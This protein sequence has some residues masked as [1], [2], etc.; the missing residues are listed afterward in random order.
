MT[1]RRVIYH[2]D[3]HGNVA[4]T[5]DGNTVYV[6]HAGSLP[7][8]AILAE[9]KAGVVKPE[10]VKEADPLPNLTLRIEILDDGQWRVTPVRVAGGTQEAGAARTIAAPWAAEPHFLRQL[11]IFEKLSSKAVA[12]DGDRQLL[13][14]AARVVGEAL[15]A[16][17]LEAER[18]FLDAEARRDGPSPL[19]LLEATDDR[20][21]TLPWELV[22]HELRFPVFDGAWDVAR[23]IPAEGAP[24]LTPPEEPLRLLLNVAAP[25]GAG[26]HYEEESYRI[27]KALHHHA[28]V[29]VNEMGE[30]EDLAAAVKAADAA[31]APLVGVH[32][33]GHGG[34]GVLLFEDAFGEKAAVPVEALWRA[35]Q[36]EDLH[37]KLRFLYLGCCHGNTP[38][39]SGQEGE[40]DGEG[41]TATAAQLHRQG[42]T[43]VVAFHGPVYDRQ[44]TAAE[45]AFYRALGAGERTRRAL[46]AARKE[47]ARP[48]H[49]TFREAERTPLAAAESEG[50]TPFAWAK[51]V[52]YHRGPDYP[53]GTP[54]TARLPVAEAEAAPRREAGPAFPGARTQVLRHGFIGRRRELHRLRRELRE[55]RQLHVVQGLGGLGKSAFC[56]EALKLYRRQGHLPLSLWCA[57]VEDETAPAAALAQQFGEL[58]QRL[59]GAAQ[60]AGIVQ[61]VDRL[62]GADEPA[63]RIQSFLSVLLQASEAPLVLYLDNLESLMR[64]PEERDD[65]AAEA[66]WRDDACRALWH[67]LVELAQNTDRL[68]LL[69]SC[70]YRHPD[71]R[72]HL[73]PF[74]TLSDDAIFRMMGWFDALRRLSVWSRARLVGQVAGHPRSVEFLEPLL[75]DHGADLREREGEPPPVVDEEGAEAEWERW[76][77]P[78][79]PKLEGKL[80]ENLLF[81]AVWNR[82]LGEREQRLLVRLTV[83]RRPAPWPLAE[84]LADPGLDEEARRAALRRLLAASLLVEYRDRQPEG[85]ETVALEVHPTVAALALGQVEARAEDGEALR[86]EGYR[87]AGEVLEA[88]AK[89]GDASVMADAGHYLFHGGEVD[90]A[91]ELLWPLA[92]W[93]SEQG[94]HREALAL[95]EELVA[96]EVAGE[97]RQL[98]HHLAFAPPPRGFCQQVE[99]RP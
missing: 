7:D 86:R 93:L 61:Q 29:Q 1:D 17:L 88:V 90:R 2:E 37:R 58:A 81:E 45:S 64:L 31:G 13:G 89:A 94:R 23:T 72:R 18:A 42:I 50:A 57:E 22:R 20:I 82:L 19:L 83:L 66:P 53:L 26:L 62:P 95:L 9:L 34:P 91:A 76:V 35:V 79:L 38:H 43:Q 27:L 77:A 10:S 69:A 52:L 15:G 51:L 59:F 70:R 49:A 12:D 80:S 65:A 54:V 48:F 99:E 47:L 28:G 39:L 8:P 3:A 55:G 41:I 96:E 24:R 63:V 78:V 75:A 4:V 32:F 40:Q 98:L 11:G 6:F 46:R 68:A 84:A 5:G 97:P 74:P 30:L 67:G 92:Q 14:A 71:F 73:F 33:S 44:A 56:Q 87:M 60:W 25:E 36:G 16:V 21:L 85:G